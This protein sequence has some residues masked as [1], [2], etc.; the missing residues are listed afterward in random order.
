MIQICN[1]PDLLFINTLPYKVLGK[2]LVFDHHDL[3]PELF[4][5]KFGR[6]GLLHHLLLLAERLTMKSADIVISANETFRT[7]AIERCG[8]SPARRFHSLQRA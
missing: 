5:V 8:K 4:A 2:R 7:I 6:K 3:C 1:P